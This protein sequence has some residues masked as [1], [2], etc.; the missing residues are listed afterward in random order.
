MAFELIVFDWDGTLMDSEAR[1]VACLQKAFSELDLPVPTREAAR[2]IIGLGL[3]EAMT[4]LHPGVS[5]EVRAELVLHYRR[6]F[7]GGDPTPSVLFPGVR[8]TLDWIVSAGYRLAVATGKSRAGLD[9]SIHETGLEGYFHATRCADETF[10]KPNPQMLFELMDE[11]GASPRETLMIGDTEYDMQMA[12]NARVG[13]LA[14][15]YG[16]HARERLM[17]HAPLGCLN[18]LTELRPWLERVGA[19]RSENVLRDTT[20]GG[21]TG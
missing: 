18:A 14:V 19:N 6:H 4:R 20:A 12:G 9:R 10:S 3:D 2:D 21:V 17:S 5:A 1:I 8:E 7:L 15:S 16:V 13:A 11:L